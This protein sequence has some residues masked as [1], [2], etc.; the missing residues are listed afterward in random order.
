MRSVRPPL[1]LRCVNGELQKAIRN[2][3]VEVHTRGDRAQELQACMSCR[4]RSSGK[5]HGNSVFQRLVEKEKEKAG[6]TRAH[7][8]RRE[9]AC[10][11][12]FLSSF[13]LDTSTASHAHSAG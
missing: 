10:T 1:N 4:F 8:V 9:L 11:I 7:R 5:N 2:K 12:S 3:G 6:M 13:A